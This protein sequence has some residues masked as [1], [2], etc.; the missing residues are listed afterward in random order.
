VGKRTRI[1]FLVLA[2]LAAAVIGAAFGFAWHAPGR[3]K[4]WTDIRTWGTFAVVVA[5]F[6]V[7]AIELNMQR[8]QFAAEVVRSKARDR[9]IDDQH[10][11]LQD[12]QLLRERELAERVDLTFDDMSERQGSSLAVVINNA[13]RPIRDV[14][15]QCYETPDGAVLP[16]D[17][18][19]DVVKIGVDGQEIW[20][21][22]SPTA[23]P[24]W[25]REVIRAGTRAGYIFS[26][27]KDDKPQVRAAVRFTDDR[28]LHWELAQDLHLKKLNDRDW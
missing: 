3:P 10:K 25:R 28:G 5:G 9:L 16:A 22:A 18:Y 21:F 13:R 12:A 15:V 6:T 24:G 20:T 17:Q 23:K 4:T 1:V 26:F 27:V 14:A 8:I 19:G 7:A 11:E 2:L